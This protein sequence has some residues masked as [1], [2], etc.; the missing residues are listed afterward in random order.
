MTGPPTLRD[1]RFEEPLNDPPADDEQYAFH[2]FFGKSLEEAE[3]LFVENAI[4]YQE[5]LM[6]MPAVCSRYYLMAYC[7]YWFRHE[8]RLLGADRE[9]KLPGLPSHMPQGGIRCQAK[10]PRSP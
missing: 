9:C 4:Y 6:W 7:D 2:H 5:D 8:L 10:P 3:L 1:W